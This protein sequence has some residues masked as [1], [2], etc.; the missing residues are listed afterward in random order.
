MSDDMGNLDGRSD[1]RQHWLRV[2]GGKASIRSSSGLAESA[3]SEAVAQLEVEQASNAKT[4][5]G[6]SK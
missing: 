1:A 2:Y 3:S 5:R 4:Q 6:G